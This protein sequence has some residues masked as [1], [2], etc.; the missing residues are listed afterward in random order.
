V[1]L[2]RQGRPA[3]LGPWTAILHSH[4]PPPSPSPPSP[5]PFLTPN[6]PSPS[7]PPCCAGAWRGPTRGS[8]RADPRPCTPAGPASR[9]YKN[10]GWLTELKQAQQTQPARSSSSSPVLSSSP[11]N[12]VL[13]IVDYC[14]HKQ[15]YFYKNN[16][17]QTK[18][19]INNDQNNI[20][21]DY[22]WLLFLSKQYCFC[23]LFIVFVHC[24][25]FIVHCL[26]F[27]VLFHCLLFFIIVYCHHFIVECQ[28]CCH[29]TILLTWEV[30]R[31]SWLPTGSCMVEYIRP[32]TVSATSTWDI[33]G[34][35]EERLLLTSNWKMAGSIKE[36]PTLY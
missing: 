29:C 6:H 12:I 31:C 34:T 8:T 24:S 2:W 20:V 16:V 5:S 1:R 21:F 35:I 32:K 36:T 13:I 23:L 27:I 28:Y 14:F 30:L 3:R 7:A 26:L 4:S 33:L 15:Y 22:C 10:T 9:E 25:L 19:I 11:N 18:T 17:L